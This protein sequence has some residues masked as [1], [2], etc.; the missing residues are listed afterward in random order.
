MPILYSCDGGGSINYQH[1]SFSATIDK[2]YDTTEIA[3]GI[4]SIASDGTDI[5]TNTLDEVFRAT[6][7][8]TTVNNSFN[9]TGTKCQD[10]S[11]DG[12]NVLASDE[13]IDDFTR[14]TTFSATVD[15]SIPTI[16]QIPR[17]ISWDGT[18]L[19]TQSLP[20]GHDEFWYRRD[21]C[22]QVNTSAL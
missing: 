19:M 7:F 14:Y 11:W 16:G 8:T 13:G 18:N 10:V 3:S 2:S 4:R 12:T 17:G 21:E 22:G 20:R 6:T 15:K 5:L 9:P 1:D